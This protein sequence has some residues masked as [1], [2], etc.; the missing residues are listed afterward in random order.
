MA[1]ARRAPIVRKRKNIVV[2]QGKLDAAKSALGTSTET[3][4][5]DAAL[6]LVVF[7]SEVFSALDRVAADG[8]FAPPG[9]SRRAG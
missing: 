3:A 8:G 4:T 7:R 5:I 9:R 2:V 6:D 1:N